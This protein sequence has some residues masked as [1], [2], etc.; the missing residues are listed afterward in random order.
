MMGKLSG[1]NFDQLYLAS[2]CKNSAN[3][4]KK[5]GKKRSPIYIP[6]TIVIG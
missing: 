4:K 2:G 3:F 1:T 5:R 6:L